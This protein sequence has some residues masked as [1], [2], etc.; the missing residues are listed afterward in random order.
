MKTATV[1][2]SLLLLSCVPK[3]ML[4]PQYVGPDSATIKISSNFS[5]GITYAD[6]DGNPMAEIFCQKET[7]ISINPGTHV[8]TA[9]AIDINASRRF[10]IDPGQTKYFILNMGFLSPVWLE[11]VK[12]PEYDKIIAYGKKRDI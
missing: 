11:E 3:S 2:L 7:T 1:L 4:S 8:I 9:K 5:V 10:N 12:Q 6:I